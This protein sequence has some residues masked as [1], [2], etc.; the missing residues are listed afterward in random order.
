MKEVALANFAHSFGGRR[1]SVPCSVGQGADLTTSAA[2]LL[3]S[4]RDRSGS[5]RHARAEPTL[6]ACVPSGA[7]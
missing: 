5:S 7:Q 6:P 4:S 2:Y 1:P 3:S